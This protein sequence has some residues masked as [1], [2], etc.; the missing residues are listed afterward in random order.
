MVLSNVPQRAHFMRRSKKLFLL[1]AYGPVCLQL[2]E[3]AAGDHA[4]FKAYRHTGSQRNS[5]EVRF[6]GQILRDVC[7]TEYT[8]VSCATVAVQVWDISGEDHS[9][10]DLAMDKRAAIERRLREEDE[11]HGDEI[12]K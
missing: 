11:A 3:N 8:T 2:A 4:W 9:S 6:Y 5:D 1:L 12:T 7:S 10:Q